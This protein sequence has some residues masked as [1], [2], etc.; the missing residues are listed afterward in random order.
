[1]AYMRYWS[2]EK[3]KMKNKSQV[4]AIVLSRDDSTRMKKI[5]NTFYLIVN[6]K[7]DKNQK[8]Q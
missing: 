7:K 3:N 2:K 6:G 4:I 1:M 5:S 8:K